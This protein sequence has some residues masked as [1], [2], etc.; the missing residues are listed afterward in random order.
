MIIMIIIIISTT[1]S[2]GH[3]HHYLRLDPIPHHEANMPDD[4]VT[5][6][7][8]WMTALTSIVNDPPEGLERLAWFTTRPF[9]LEK[10]SELPVATGGKRSQC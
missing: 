9:A 2:S 7:H 3:V 8:D 6:P 5:H 4:Q 10:R 1:T